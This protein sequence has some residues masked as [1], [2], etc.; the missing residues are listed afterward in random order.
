V[1]KRQTA[2]QWFK[3]VFAIGAAALCCGIC[4][5]AQNDEKN[6]HEKLSEPANAVKN[7]DDDTDS[8]KRA[9][10]SARKIEPKREVVIQTHAVS[11]PDAGVS[12][13]AP[14]DAVGKLCF[15]PIDDVKGQRGIHARLAEFEAS[16]SRQNSVSRRN[17]VIVRV[18]K[19]EKTIS[20]K[21]GA[22]FDGLLMNEAHMISMREKGKSKPYFQ[23]RLNF[24]EAGGSPLCVYDN[25]LYNTTQISEKARRPFCKKC[26]SSPVAK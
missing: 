23:Y 8:G 19:Q 17:K 11:A 14:A 2:I 24:Q 13:P 3:N 20:P 5:S 25:G 10:D 22:V 4:C 1:E 18:G 26:F 16:V 15:A 12:A 9:G 6:L 7:C 21:K